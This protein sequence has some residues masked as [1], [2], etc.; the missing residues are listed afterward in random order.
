[1]DGECQV[2]EARLSRG[3]FQSHQSQSC[4]TVQPES[5]RH[6]HIDLL[7]PAASRQETELGT[8]AA[9]GTIPK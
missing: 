4:P 1:M 8:A 6:I 7:Q 5:P 3:F 2:S 9:R